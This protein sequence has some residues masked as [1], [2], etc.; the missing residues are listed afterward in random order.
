MKKIKK[1]GW[2]ARRWQV[3]VRVRW[4]RLQSR[5]AAFYFYRVTFPLRFWRACGCPE[6][7]RPSLPW[8]QPFVLAWL[9]LSGWQR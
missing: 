2:A 8:W 9:R 1:I 7:F 5:V 3:V 4:D 6:Q